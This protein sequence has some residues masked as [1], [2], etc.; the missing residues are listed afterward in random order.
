MIPA[1]AVDADRP[2]GP[3]GTAYVMRA[4][5]GKGSVIS[6]ITTMIQ[7]AVVDGRSL[8]DAEQAVARQLQVSPDGLYLN[9]AVDKTGPDH[10]ALASAA[11]DLIVPSLQSGVALEVAGAPVGPSYNVSDF[12]YLDAGNWYWRALAN[13][14]IADAQGRY[15][16]RD[17]RA[18]QVDGIASAE[19]ALYGLAAQPFRLT[20]AGWIQCGASTLHYTTVGNP[21]IG[22]FCGDRE[23]SV[24]EF[25]D[26]SGKPLA[27]GVA[28]ASAFEGGAASFNIDAAALGNAV[29]PSGAALFV[30]TGRVHEYAIRYSEADGVINSTMTQMVQQTPVPAAATGSNT[31]SVGSLRDASGN[32]VKRARAAFGPG[33]SAHYYLCDVANEVSVNCLPAGTGTWAQSV[34]HGVPI[35]AFTDQ[36]SESSATTGSTRVFVERDGKVY[37][38]YRIKPDSVSTQRI[39][40][41]DIA[42]NALTSQLGIQTPTAP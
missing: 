28:A 6:P 25:T 36:P 5:A 38:G 16:F 34:L 9:Y 27:S 42:M 14:A 24:R 8:T 35:I 19:D 29:F 41:N 20:S 31:V 11:S 18:G 15:T 30:R 7:G 23:G 33:G 12:R 13:E 1:D 40:F 21:R 10:A 39:R 4:P 32:I 26:L 37:Y 3:V 2:D 22:V 17:K